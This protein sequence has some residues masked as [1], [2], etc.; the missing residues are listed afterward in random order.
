[1]DNR[2]ALAPGRLAG[3]GIKADHQ[4]RFEAL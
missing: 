2:A 4:A 3:M 1:M